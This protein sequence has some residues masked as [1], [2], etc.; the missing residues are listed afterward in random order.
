MQ[1]YTISI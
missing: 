1:D